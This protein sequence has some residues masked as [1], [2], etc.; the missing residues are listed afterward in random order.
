MVTANTSLDSHSPQWFVIRDS[1]RVALLECPRR[2][3]MFWWSYEVS[4]LPEVIVDLYTPAFWEDVF[5][6][7][8]ARS[9]MRIPGVF[10]GKVRPSA[11]RQRVWLR[12]F[13]PNV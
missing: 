4:E 2:E 3:D 13:I 6:I 7:E 10:A 12:G 9:G 11:P 1:K 5:E 8:D